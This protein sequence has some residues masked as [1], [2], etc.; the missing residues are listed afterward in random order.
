MRKT[1]K[2]KLYKSKKNKYL[3][4]QIDLGNQIYNHFIAVHKRYFRLYK[5]YPS[6]FTMNKHLTKLKKL[7]RFSH[8]KFFPSQAAQNIIERIDFGYK[9]FFRKENLRP[10][11]FRARRKAKSF[12]LKQAGW[13]LLEGNRVKIGNRTFKYSKS[14]EVQG[15]IKTVTIKRDPLGDVSIFFSCLLSDEE[16]SQTKTG[17]IAGFDFGLKT[18]LTSSEGNSIESPL[19]YKQGMKDLK[20][21]QRNLSS[22]KKG[23]H[24]RKKARLA[25]AR[26]HKKVSNQRENHHFQLAKELATAYEV[27]CIEDLNLKGM[28]KLWGRKVNDLAFGDFVKTLEW[29]CQKY[30]SKLIK[31]DRF[32]PSSKTCSSCYH[33]YEDLELIE[34]SWKCDKCNTEHDRD[35]NAALNIKRV[36]MSTLAGED[37]RLAC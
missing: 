13:K 30:G 1:Y 8:W 2:F 31:I 26:V 15:V 11:A 4:G 7:K 24:N 36:G 22:K 5:K 3:H 34:R 23:S 28:V 33:L 9:K 19:F 12:T 27:I 35:C 17:K 20:K 14:Q 25:L 10:P 18:F 16:V 37:V 32:Y 29:Q 6:A 21:A